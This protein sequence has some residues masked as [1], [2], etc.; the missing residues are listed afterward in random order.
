MI[1]ELNNDLINII[2]DYIQDDSYA[3]VESCKIFY[4]AVK[5][6]Y[7]RNIKNVTC[8]RKIKQITFGKVKWMESHHGFKYNHELSRIA[9]RNGDRKLVNYLLKNGCPY[10][11]VDMYFEAIRNDD[12]NIEKE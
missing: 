1:T 8:F 10:Y 7:H 12:R 5:K 3:F 2:F 11:S 4:E 6:D 9:C